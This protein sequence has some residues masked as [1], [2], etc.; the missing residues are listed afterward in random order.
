VPGGLGGLET[1]QQLR[2]IDPAVRALVSSGYSRDPVMARYAEHGFCGVVSKPYRLE[3]L[4]AAL[5]E[6]LGGSA[7]GSADP[8]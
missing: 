1:L 8:T 6:A 7:P 5:D 4:G 3:E 2:R